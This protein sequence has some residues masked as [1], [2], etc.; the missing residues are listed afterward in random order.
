[1]AR[2]AAR[3]DV[4]RFPRRLLLSQHEHHLVADSAILPVL[5]FTVKRFPN[6]PPQYARA[7]YHLVDVP[8]YLGDQ[9]GAVLFD[10][11]HL[12]GGFSFIPGRCQ[13]RPANKPRRGRS[14]DLPRLIRPCRREN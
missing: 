6:Y 10:L 8:T 7:L 11:D 4:H 9:F 1:M 5:P 3:R 2:V 13:N 12:H 14:P